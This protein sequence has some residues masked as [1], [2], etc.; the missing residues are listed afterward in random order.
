MTLTLPYLTKTLA[1]E[2]DTIADKFLVDH[3][4]ALYSNPTLAP[5]PTASANHWRPIKAQPPTPLRDLVWDCKKALIGVRKGM[6]RYR[7]VD[8]KG[9]VD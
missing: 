4:I 9:Q 6:E 5:A 7:V 3:D 8:L 1:F 2:S